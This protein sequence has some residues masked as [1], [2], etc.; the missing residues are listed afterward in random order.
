VELFRIYAGICYF[1]G[2]NNLFQACFGARRLERIMKVM[3]WSTAVIV[4]PLN[5]RGLVLPKEP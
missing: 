3:R 2:L 1:K 5:F 4:S